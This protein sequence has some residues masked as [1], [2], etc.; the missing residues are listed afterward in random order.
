MTKYYDIKMPKNINNFIS[1]N[2]VVINT[3]L[4]IKHFK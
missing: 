4:L 3:S 1:F 2:E